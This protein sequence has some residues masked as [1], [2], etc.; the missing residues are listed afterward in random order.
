LR[1]GITHPTFQRY[2]DQKTDGKSDFK[3][4]FRAHSHL[5]RKAESQK[6]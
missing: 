3:D 6:L 5:G 4:A 1:K 2:I